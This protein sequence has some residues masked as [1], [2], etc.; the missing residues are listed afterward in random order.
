MSSPVAPTR[1]LLVAH[2]PVA[3]ALATAARRIVGT[4]PLATTCVD[5]VQSDHQNSDDSSQDDAIEAALVAPGAT[6]IL[7]DIAGAT[8]CNH[9]CRLAD[10]RPRTEIVAGLG[11]A[12]LLRVYNYHDRDLAALAELAAESGQRT[13]QRL[14]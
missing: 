10:A 12:M 9:V 5:Y 14:T 8:P 1:L 7:V 13:T 6:L 2:A 3:S 4:A 11:L